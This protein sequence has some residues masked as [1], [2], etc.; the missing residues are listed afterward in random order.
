MHNLFYII[1]FT[2]KNDIYNFSFLKFGITKN[3]HLRKKQIINN[4]PDGVFIQK[5]I[6]FIRTTDFCPNIFETIVKRTLQKKISENMIYNIK[7]IFPFP[8]SNTFSKEM[9]S[10]HFLL[11]IE[12]LKISSFYIKPKQEKEYMIFSF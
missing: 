9:S 10:S 11:D 6:F 5:E 7:N 2:F 8:I 4:L 1:L 12:K 3:Y